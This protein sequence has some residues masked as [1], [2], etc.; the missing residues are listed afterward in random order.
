MRRLL[1]AGLFGIALLITTAGPALAGDNYGAM[2]GAARSMSHTIC[3][4]H[5]SF[6]AFGKIDNFGAGIGNLSGAP[7]GPNGVGA[8]GTATGDNNSGLCG[9]SR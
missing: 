2:P 9:V 4:A 5:G 3:A 8:N 1:A 6:G 7:S